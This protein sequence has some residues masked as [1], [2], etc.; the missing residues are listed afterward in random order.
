[1][2]LPT[3]PTAVATTQPPLV[4]VAVTSLGLNGVNSDYVMDEINEWA[5][6]GIAFVSRRSVAEDDDESYSPLLAPGRQPEML[7]GLAAATGAFSGLLS[8]RREG[9]GILVDVSRQEVQAAMLHS[10]IP[11]FVWNGVVQGSSN[12]RLSGVGMLLPTKDGQIYLRTVEAH[13][14]QSLIEFIGNP[15]WANEDWMQ[16]PMKRFEMR[17]AIQTLVG[18]WTADRET[19]W[20]YREGQRRGVPFALPRTLDQVLGSE[21][22][23]IRNFWES[24]K[25]GEGEGRAPS[26]PLLK[27]ES[28]LQPPRAVTFEELQN[29]WT[30]P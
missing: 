17:S 16:D 20:V 10:S 21:Q 30:K 14:F 26:V 8:V 2:S 4:V 9:K 23:E 27:G 28:T 3:D 25:L 11:S 1:M 13:Q 7:G 22:E 19:E 24:I 5:S 15:D 18:E 29:L 6:G 12:V